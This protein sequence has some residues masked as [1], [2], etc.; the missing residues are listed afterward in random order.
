MSSHNR[1]VTLSTLSH[2][3]SILNYWYARSLSTD[4]LHRQAPRVRPIAQALLA[5]HLRCPPPARQVTLN[6][7][8]GSTLC[9]SRSC[10]LLLAAKHLDGGI[11]A[12]APAPQHQ[13]DNLR[14]M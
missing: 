13:E 4:A 12:N 3:Q 9:R 10:L 11:Y 1:A 7:P 5:R 2:T 14:A 8:A 6:W